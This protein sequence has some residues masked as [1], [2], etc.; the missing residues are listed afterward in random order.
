MYTVTDEQNEIAEEKKRIGQRLRQLR[1]RHG[2]S[3]DYIATELDTTQ[4]VISK[5]ENGVD[6]PGGLRLK[7]LAELY[8]VTSDFILGIVVSEQEEHP[9]REQ[10]DL[11]DKLEAAI[12]ENNLGEVTE[13]IARLLQKKD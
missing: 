9:A 10:S 11:I 3:Q 5:Y 8:E 13:I 12:A 6:V 7:K 4:Q 2:F 1:E